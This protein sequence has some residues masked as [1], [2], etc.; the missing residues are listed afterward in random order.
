MTKVLALA[1][2]LAWPAWAGAQTI[3]PDDQ[4]RLKQIFPTGVCD[5]TKPSQ[6]QV[7]FAGTWPRY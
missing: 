5:W 2:A 3:R 6:H 4:A 1:V 7:P